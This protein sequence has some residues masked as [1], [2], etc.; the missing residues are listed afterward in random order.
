MKKCLSI[1]L[2]LGILFGMGCN[3]VERIGS[4]GEQ[5]FYVVR[6]SAFEGPNVAALYTD[7]GTPG[8]LSI[9]GTFAADGVLNA[10]VQAG[11]A[12]AAAEVQ[13]A[14]TTEVRLLNRAAP[15]PRP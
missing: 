12:V 11:G 4:V 15:P 5:S 7:D 9:V 8:S 10:A 3:R 1:V 14:D 6:S 13:D 2:G